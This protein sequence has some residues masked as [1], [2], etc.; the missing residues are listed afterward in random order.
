M[1]G[2][3]SLF[4]MFPENG[5]I[6]TCLWKCITQHP[7]VEPMDER[8]KNLVPDG[9]FFVRVGGHDLVLRPTNLKPEEVP[10]GHEFYHYLVNGAVFS[11]IFVG[12]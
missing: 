8:K 4:D 12:N 6:A 5:L 9:E 7:L 10:A 11:G 2:Q 1:L 3:M